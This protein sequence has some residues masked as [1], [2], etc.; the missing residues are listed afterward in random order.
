M[1]DQKCSLSIAIKKILDKKILKLILV[2]EMTLLPFEYRQLFWIFKKKVDS[3]FA[4]RTIKSDVS[5][6]SD[7]H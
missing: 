5:D 1:R 3:Y 7:E 2:L 4:G 6:I